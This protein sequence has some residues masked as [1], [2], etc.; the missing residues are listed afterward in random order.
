MDQSP[1]R[2][3]RDIIEGRPA[4]PAPIR[5]FHSDCAGVSL[6]RNI[7]IRE[8]QGSLLAFTDDDAVPDPGWLEGFAAAFACT[9]P[10]AGLVGGRSYR[11]GKG[12]GLG[13][14]RPRM[15]ISSPFSTQAARLRRFPKARS[16]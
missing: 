8:S 14:T 9:K 4:G 1:D 12:R 15:N 13:G 10:G 16:R 2:T 3:T 5:Y 6:A 7:G 11:F